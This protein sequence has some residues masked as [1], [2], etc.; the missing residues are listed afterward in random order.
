MVFLFLCDVESQLKQAVLKRHAR[1]WI[2][3]ITHV[4]LY[5]SGKYGSR[6]NDFDYWRDYRTVLEPLMHKY[7]VD[8][9]VSGNEHMYEVGINVSDMVLVVF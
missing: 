1:P 7:K 9:V 8:V 5:S 6:V 2:V 4:P 3:V